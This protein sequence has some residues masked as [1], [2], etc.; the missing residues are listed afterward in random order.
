MSPLSVYYGSVPRFTGKN[1]LVYYAKRIGTT[2]DMVNKNGVLE[3][4]A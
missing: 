4:P 1:S 2:I 3:N